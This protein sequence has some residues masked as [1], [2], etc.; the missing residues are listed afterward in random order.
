[1]F[2]YYIT[3]KTLTEPFPAAHEDLMHLISL[4]RKDEII[5]MEIRYCKSHETK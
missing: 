5:K 3:V 1:M 4:W 2:I